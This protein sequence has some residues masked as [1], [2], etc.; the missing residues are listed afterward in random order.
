MQKFNNHFCPIDLFDQIDEYWS[1]IIINEFNGNYI[2]IAKLKGEFVWHKHENEEELFI[3]LKGSLIIELKEESI[4]LNEGDN[5]VVP[6]NTLH[7][8]HCKEECWVML[9]EPK[10]TLHT[11][12]VITQ[13]S[14]SIKNQLGLAE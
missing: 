14:K 4:L 7:N 5:Y 1:P 10:E 3:I 13:K 6:K 11:G 2:K 9:I 8:P 12:D